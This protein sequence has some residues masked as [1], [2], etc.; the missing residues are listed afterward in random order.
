MKVDRVELLL[1]RLPYVHY[2]E[3]SFGR[4]ESKTFI[5]V[6]VYAGGLSGYGEVVADKNPY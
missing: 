4:E 1:L 3:T 2:F 5:V 6:K